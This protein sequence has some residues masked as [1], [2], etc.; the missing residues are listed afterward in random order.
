MALVAVVVAGVVVAPIDVVAVRAADGDGSN[1]HDLD[2]DGADDLTIAYDRS[3]DQ[4]WSQ[5]WTTLPGPS[6]GV[7]RRDFWVRGVGDSGL[8]SLWWNG[9]PGAWSDGRSTPVTGDFDGDGRAEVA[10]IYEYP[11]IGV[12]SL[13]QFAPGGAFPTLR[14]ASGEIGQLSTTDVRVLAGDVNGDGI[15]DVVALADSAG[16]VQT[17]VWY[18][19]PSGLH[20]FTR[21]WHSG[22]GNWNLASTRVAIGDVDGDGADDIVLAYQYDYGVVRIWVMP[23]GRAGPGAPQL[24][25]TSCQDCW[26]LASTQ[27]AAGDFD[28]DGRDDLAM[29]YDYGDASTGWWVIEG[30]DLAGGRFPVPQLLWLS[31][32][33]AFDASRTT[34]TAGDFDGDGTDEVRLAYNYAGYGGLELVDAAVG[35]WDLRRIGDGAQVMISVPAMSASNLIWFTPMFDWDRLRMI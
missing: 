8:D 1:S 18:G 19:S 11:D 32:R 2:G 5:I 14:W 16:E 22:V 25:W 12:S 35:F 27:L 3:P 30:Y 33:G 9:A 7:I 34:A 4:D 17:S 13:W 20:G 31:D 28:G 6:Y 15:D 21:S 10:A 24:R 29:V 23:G 26:E